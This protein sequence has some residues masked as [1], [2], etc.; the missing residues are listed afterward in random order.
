MVLVYVSWSISR[1]VWRLKSFPVH[2]RARGDVSLPLQR[3]WCWPWSCLA[4]P[5]LASPP[6]HWRLLPTTCSQLVDRKLQSKLP[7]RLLSIY[8]PNGFEP[9]SNAMSIHSSSTAQCRLPACPPS[10]SP[11]SLP[12]CPP[13]PFPVAQCL[14]QVRRGWG[15]VYTLGPKTKGTSNPRSNPSYTG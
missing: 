14:L 8:L 6:L 12:A 7:H 4:L 15:F 13:R 10:L 2:A 11:A 9:S 1:L 5:P 3:P